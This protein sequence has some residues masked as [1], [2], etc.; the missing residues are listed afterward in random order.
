MEIVNNSKRFTGDDNIFITVGSQTTLISKLA[1]KSS[2]DLQME[3][4]IYQ[5]A[6]DGNVKIATP[7]EVMYSGKLISS[8]EKVILVCKIFFIFY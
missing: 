2:I 7:E 8:I 4:V 5:H 6:E 1:L 3:I